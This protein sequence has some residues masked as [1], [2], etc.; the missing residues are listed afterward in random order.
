MRVP[1]IRYS[2]FLPF[3]YDSDKF[4]FTVFGEEFSYNWLLYIFS[5]ANL[6]AASDCL[7]LKSSEKYLSLLELVDAIDLITFLVL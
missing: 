3:F 7:S 1:V 6:P 2:F 4:I 5:N